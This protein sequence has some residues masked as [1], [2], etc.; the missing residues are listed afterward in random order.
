MGVEVSMYPRKHHHHLCCKL[1]HRPQK[2]SLALLLLLLCDK[3][4]SP[5]VCLHCKS[6]S[7]QYRTANHRR[8]A[9]RGGSLGLT[10]LVELKLHILWLTRPCFPLPQ[11][12]ATTLLLYSLLLRVWLIHIHRVSGIMTLKASCLFKKNISMPRPNKFMS[13]Q[14]FQPYHTFGW[15]SPIFITC[16]PQCLM[17][18]P[19]SM[20]VSGIKYLEDI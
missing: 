11:P 7:T 10:H 3:N 17:N 1:F 20:Q 4:T 16:F 13:L 12:L 8:Y 6:L 14:T 15:N 9:V 19:P 18:N 5:E 2:F